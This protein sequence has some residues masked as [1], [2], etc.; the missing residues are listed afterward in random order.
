MANPSR[1]PAGRTLKLDMLVVQTVHVEVI[2]NSKK[3]EPVETR[4][5]YRG[6]YHQ[7]FSESGLWGK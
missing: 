4:K 3:R 6:L 5:L 1:N 7:L 2:Y